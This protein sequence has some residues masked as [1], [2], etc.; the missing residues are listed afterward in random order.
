MGSVE[1]DWHICEEQ[2]PREQ[3]VSRLQASC[4]DEPQNSVPGDVGYWLLQAVRKRSMQRKKIFFIVFRRVEELIKV[5]EQ[6]LYR[7]FPFSFF[8]ETCSY[9]K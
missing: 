1:E 2:P 6:K 8:Y 4:V 7:V 9:A 5:Y 3:S